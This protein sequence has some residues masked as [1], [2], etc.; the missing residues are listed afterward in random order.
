MTK[1]FTPWTSNPAF[2]GVGLPSSKRAF[3][4]VDCA[5]VQA[6]KRQK[7]EVG[8]A[9]G[10]VTQL[11]KKAG[12]HK[13]L[14]VDVS[15]NHV[16]RPMSDAS[17]FLRTLTT[18]TTLY[19]Y[20][21]DRTVLPIEH[22]FLQGYEHQVSIPKS[23]AAGSGSEIRNLAGEAICLPCLASIVWCLHLTKDLTSV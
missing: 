13:D 18:S 21:A 3:D 2:K 20:E 5:W 14:F 22:L 17:G 19:S 16:R 10:N 23:I 8:K 9:T 12:V 11:G 1:G 7:I 15:Q 4:L 6:C